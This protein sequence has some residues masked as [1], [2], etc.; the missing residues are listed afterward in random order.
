MSRQRTL[1][2]SVLVLILA[3]AVV[4]A[5]I[6][7]LVLSIWDRQ[8][9]PSYIMLPTYSGTALIPPRESEGEAPLAGDPADPEQGPIAGESTGREESAVACE[10]PIHVVAGGET[11]GVIAE[12][13]GVSM[14]DAI[15]ANQMI[16]PDFNPHFLSIDQQILIPVCG[17]PEPT[18]TATPTITEV[19][20][21]NVPTPNPTG[22]EP[23]PGVIRVEVAR[24]LNPGDITNEA[25]EIINRGTSVARLGGWKLIN[26]RSG[27]EFT[28]PPL[29]LF[30]QG[31]VTVHTGVGENTAI[32]VYWGRDSA[33]W[34]AG[35][36]AQLVDA[37]GVVQHEFEIP[38]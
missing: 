21:R 2:S 29:N 36:T 8:Q 18:P 37:D 32:D 6:T 3:P 19:P 11:L 33:A 17:I 7:L 10:N 28:F 26:E 5:A 14:D 23:P 35:D 20:T 30:P 31:A 38:R 34:Q 24:V 16:D 1:L 9:G 22:T 12:S 25:V 15:I 13:Y 4:A 27:Q